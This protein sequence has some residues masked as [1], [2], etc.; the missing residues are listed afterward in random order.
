[1]NFSS[2]LLWGF[3]STLLLTTTLAL[4]QGLGMTRINMPYMLGTFFTA[5]RDRA[6][7]YGFFAHL[8]N[9]IA[10]S[11][12]YVFAFQSWGQ[13]GWWRGAL[14]GLLHGLFV[15][16]V[17]VSLLPGIHP[18]MASEQHGPEASRELEPPGFMA[19]HYGIQTPI[20]ILL[21]HG[22]YGM[23]LGAFYQLR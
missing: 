13:A 1:V 20:S 8:A 10:F 18:R 11:L 19:I 6:R 9:G 22:V 4:S 21:A 15:M 2:W 5:D 12:I 7:I 17:G 16:V 14:I 23:V 3:V